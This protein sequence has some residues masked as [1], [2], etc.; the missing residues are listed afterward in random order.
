MTALRAWRPIYT[1]KVAVLLERT[2]ATAA[3]ANIPK[4]LNRRS[5]SG[6]R[7]LSNMFLL[8]VLNRANL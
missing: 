3:A 8:P 2:P 6:V 7:L 5:G 1:D 4:K